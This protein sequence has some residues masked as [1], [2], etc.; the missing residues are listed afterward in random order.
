[1]KTAPPEIR[2]S[3]EPSPVRV[4]PPAHAV[5]EPARPAAPQLPAAS[6]RTRWWVWVLI[7]AVAAGL[8]A[9]LV[10][11]IHAVKAASAA[12]A[13]A[14]A[15]GRKGGTHDLPVVVAT[16]RRGDLPVYL[17]GL[18]TVT[19]LKTVNLLTRVDGTI[20]EIHYTEGQH[21]KA[22]DFLLQIDPRPYQ[23]VLDQAKGQLIKDQ[24]AKAIAEWNVKQDTEALKTKAIAEQQL[25]T[26]EAA[27]DTAIG[28]IEVDQANIE[29][30]QVNLDYCHVTSPID[31]TIGLRLV[32]VGNI[33]HAAGTTS[34]A[35]ITQEQPITVVF[36]LVED[37]L[38]QL[39]RRM[40]TGQPVRVDAYD[41]NLTH[42]LARGTLLAVD[43]TIDPTTG[44]IKIKAQ[45]DNK[46]NAL[47]PSQFVN[48][49]VL[50]DTIRQAVLV[51][52]PAIQHN[53]TGAS[54]VYKVE[55]GNTVKMV[56]VT[57]GGAALSAVDP[58][59]A[60]TTVV[61]AGVEP[62][63]VVV[64][65]GVDKLTDGTK[66]TPRTGETAGGHRGGAGTRPTTGPV[67]PMDQTGVGGPQMDAAGA[68]PGP[69]TRPHHHRPV[70][71]PVE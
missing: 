58:D 24:A 61:A 50:V 40:N 18:G 27:R 11:R 5:P 26:D 28:S 17:Y 33:V 6:G 59:E 19:P 43:S 42:R 10:H 51:P 36:T 67:E 37:E 4:P 69:T 1:M 68:M 57:L 9:L 38:E 16:A 21:V 52:T 8:A 20:T 55:D 48:A 66:V 44:T 56:P 49:R 45:F 39:L 31:G 29:A 63:D 34:L 35:V 2:R 54:F 14:T 22:G 47:Y 13:T 25:Q 60:D 62:G 30:A 3:A 32:D 46:D 23:A 41:R 64:T 12:A 15:G 70:A 65:D 53:S 7:V 71:D